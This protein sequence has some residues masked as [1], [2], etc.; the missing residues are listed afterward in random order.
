MHVRQTAGSRLADAIPEA[1]RALTAEKCAERGIRD[2]LPIDSS[3]RDQPG[4]RSF[5]LLRASDNQDHRGSGRRASRSRIFPA[6]RSGIAEA[7]WLP[8]VNAIIIIRAIFGVRR[9][10]VGGGTNLEGRPMM[11]MVLTAGSHLAAAI[12]LR[13]AGKMRLRLAT[14]PPPRRSWLSEALSNGKERR[15]G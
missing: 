7:R 4:R 3:L 5:P 10:R 13:R 6:R 1:G 8:A 11:I 12:P 15:P 9:R 2:G 14:L